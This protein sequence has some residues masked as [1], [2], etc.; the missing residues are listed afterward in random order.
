M[1]FFLYLR[2]GLCV[3][4]TMLHRHN[5][6][7]PFSLE[8]DEHLVQFLAHRIPYKSSGGRLG[9]GVYKDLCDER[10]VLTSMTL[11]EHALTIN[12]F[13]LLVIRGQS[14]IRGSLGAT[15]IPRTNCSL[16]NVST[17]KST[18]N[19]TPPCPEIKVNT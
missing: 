19:Q 12:Q 11:E 10:R 2:P 6:R 18:T 15:G 3:T 14:T 5:A 1:S 13:R 7:T 8:D 9:N 4:Q 17:T 16:T